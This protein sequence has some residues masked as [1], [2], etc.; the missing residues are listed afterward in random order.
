VCSGNARTNSALE[1]PIVTAVPVAGIA[2][3]IRAFVGGAT[4]YTGREV[5]RVLTDLGAV[6]TAHVRPDS[7]SLD[8]WRDRFTQCG[9]R[10]DSTPWDEAAMTATLRRLRPT[11]V[12][13]LLGTTRARAKREARPGAPRDAYES[14]DYGLTALIL[15]ATRIAAPR[16]RFIYL[17][18]LGAR[19]DTRNSY[20]RVRGRLERE[21][22][23][24]GLAYLIARPSFITGPDR[25]ETR[26]VE[27]L[28]AAVVDTAMMFA[29]VVGAIA[30]RDRY[31]SMTGAQLAEAM[32]AL[33]LEP[34]R[35]S[36]VADG[37]DFQAALR[38]QASAGRPR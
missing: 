29:G 18:S 23:A 4:G 10:V 31:G 11:L 22:A 7:P 14:V 8:R 3:D 21:I 25:D 15:A 9:A 34:G 2:D 38:R 12:F 36:G 6:V 13:A 37:V 27:R 28:G 19:E 1:D 5:V 32:V 33:A 16:S 24:S 17:S 30:A 26:P 20:L 35:K